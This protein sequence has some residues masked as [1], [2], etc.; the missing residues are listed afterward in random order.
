MPTFPKYRGNLPECLNPLDPGH[1]WLLAYWVYFRPSALSCY[2]YQ[3]APECKDLRGLRKVRLTWSITAYRNLY[4][5]LPVAVLLFALLVGSLV[6][7]YLLWTLQGHTDWVKAVAVTPD[8]LQAVSAGADS[9]VR[10]W[11]LKSG[12][13]LRTLEGH[14]ASVNAV[15]V[16]PDSLQAVSAGDDSTA[17]VWDLKSGKFLRTLQGH[18]TQV[19]G[20]AVTPDSQQAVSAGADGTLRVWDLKSGKSLRTLQGHSYPVRSVAVTSNGEQVIS[21]SADGSLRLWDL[22]S[23]AAV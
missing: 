14:T 20:V 15:A 16:T 4:L 2:L 9:T 18:T 22:K 17:R 13:S 11:D 12:K 19:L 21:A 10:V 7:L 5:M 3:A 23:G 1:Y 8:S 6:G